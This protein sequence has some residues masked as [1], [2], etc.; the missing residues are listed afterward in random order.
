MKEMMVNLSRRLNNVFKEKSNIIILL[1]ILNL[2]LVAYVYVEILD[3]HYHF[4]M[5]TKTSLEH[6]QNTIQGAENFKFDKYD[7]TPERQLSTEEQLV[8]K[9]NHKFHLYFLLKNFI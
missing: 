9:N 4:Y 5:N 7:G 1:L 8:R 3:S 2:W 6:I